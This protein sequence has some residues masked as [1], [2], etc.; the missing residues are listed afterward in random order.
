MTSAPY[1][2]HRPSPTP[3]HVGIGRPD[4]APPRSQPIYR[5]VLPIS[6]YLPLLAHNWRLIA[7]V[8]VLTVGV[9]YGVSAVLPRIYESTAIVDLAPGTEERLINTDIK[10]IQSAVVLQPVI[11]AYPD[12][13]HGCSVIRPLGTLTLLVSCRSAEAGRATQMAAATA[14]SFVII[15]SAESFSQQLSSTK[16]KILAQLRTLSL[17][18]AKA[19]AERI[20]REAHL[21]GTGA[22]PNLTA[23]RADQEYRGAL[24]REAELRQ[25]IS[26]AQNE[27]ANLNAQVISYEPLLAQAVIDPVR[28]D[29]LLRR[30]KET[31]VNAGFAN[32][33]AHVVAVVPS[34]RPVSPNVKIN[35]LL[36]LVCSGFAAVAFVILRSTRGNIISR[37]DQITATASVD[38]LGIADLPDPGP[39]RWKTLGSAA[40]VELDKSIEMMVA[41]V[42]TRLVGPSAMVVTSATGA[43]DRRT[44]TTAL[45]VAGAKHGRTTLLI[46]AALDPATEDD[47]KAPVPSTLLSA[48]GYK[49]VDYVRLSNKDR[50]HVVGTDQFRNNTAVLLNEFAKKY[51]FVVI[52]GPPLLGY[53]ETEIL[54]CVAQNALVV[55]KEGAT[56]RYDLLSVC[57]RLQR[58]GVNLLGVIL[59]RNCKKPLA[60]QPQ[61]VRSV[62]Q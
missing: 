8:I 40:S 39:D 48:A 53:L 43:E 24:Q 22:P 33:P 36:A 10:R 27:L 38:I 49:N 56:L 7:I 58:S 26:E 32:D 1:N 23:L 42:F 9:T 45:A 55:A 31:S 62:A 21:A 4:L 16:A 5:P 2:N 50:A 54:A 61:A 13:E 12:A 11:A 60:T 17:E 3:D 35:L 29:E 44:V 59:A 51:D 34:G 46:D 14:R 47:S 52:E 15:T 19:E 6:Q 41:S 30:I 57:D 25:T 18:R 37:P 28:Y 20:G